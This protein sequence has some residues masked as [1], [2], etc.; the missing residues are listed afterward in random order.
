MKIKN[1]ALDTM[2]PVNKDDNFDES[3][4]GEYGYR[5]FYDVNEDEE[6]FRQSGLA[7]DGLDGE[8]AGGQLEFTVDANCALIGEAEVLLWIT[9]KDDE[10][11]YT[12]ADFV[13]YNEDISYVVEDLKKQKVIR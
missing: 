11:S 2:I 13:N 12:N 9:C 7:T 5:V 6:F 3:K 4:N 8:F 1:F 10:G